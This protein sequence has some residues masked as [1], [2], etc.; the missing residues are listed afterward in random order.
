[1]GFHEV[2]WP[3]VAFVISKAFS[4]EVVSALLGALLWN[5][6]PQQTAKTSSPSHGY[7]FRIHANISLTY[8]HMYF[9]FCSFFDYR[10][11]GWRRSTRVGIIGG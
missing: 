9:L 8:P 2:S 1:M 7:G 6:E 11:R 3:S 10:G 5:N 4:D